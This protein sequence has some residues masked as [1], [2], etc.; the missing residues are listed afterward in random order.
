MNSFRGSKYHERKVL[1]VSFWQ[2]ENSDD[3]DS[4]TEPQLNLTEISCMFFRLYNEAGRCWP[5]YVCNA[6]SIVLNWFMKFFNMFAYISW[7]TAALV[8]LLFLSHQI[9][10]M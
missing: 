3:K 10:Q 9:S 8:V 2:N 1:K 4:Y 7:D 6:F 5:M